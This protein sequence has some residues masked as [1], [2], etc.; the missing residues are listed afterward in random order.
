MFQPGDCLGLGL[1][2]ANE[3]GVIGILTMDGFNGYIAAD[4]WLNGNM[5]RT[6]SPFANLFLELISLDSL[7]QGLIEAEVAGCYLLVDL[8]RFFGR[9]P[10]KLFSQ[11]P[12]AVL[13]DGHGL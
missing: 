3:L 6:I 1:E 5:D 7:N 10:R 12:L 11:H 13:I 4:G 8:G 9:G 2:P